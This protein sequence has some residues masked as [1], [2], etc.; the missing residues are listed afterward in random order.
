MPAVTVHL[1]SRA[2]DVERFFRGDAPAVIVKKNRGR[3]VWRVTAG[4]PALFVKRFPRELLRDRARHEADVLRAMAEAGL[5]C[6]RLVATAKDG[7]GSYVVTE[8][9]AGAQVLKALIAGGGHD[10]RRLLGAFADL[11]RRLLDAGFEHGDYHIGNVLVRDGEM[12]V[13]DVHRARKRR[14]TAARRADVVAFAAMSFL[15]LVPRTEVVRYIRKCGADAQDAIRRLRRHRRTYFE[16]RQERCFVE[17]SGFGADGRVFYRKGVDLEAVRAAVKAEGQT[18]KRTGS[19]SLVRLPRG[20]FV[21]RTTAARAKRIWGGAH[22]L[23]VRGIPTPRLHA[24]GPG[25]VVGDWIDAPNLGDVVRERFPVLPRGERD[26]LIFR[27]ARLVRRMHE[28]GALHK[29]LKSSNVLVGPAGFHFVDLDRVVTRSEVHQRQWT[30]ALAQLSASVHAAATRA[31]R[32]RFLYAYIGST[33][34]LWLRRREIAA[35]IM[36]QTRARKHLWP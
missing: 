8:E 19:E 31:D 23:A 10:A 1:P 33:R 30:F 7:E 36:K 32:L 2:P 24:C 4:E 22:A 17:G 21:K 34:A 35:A 13:L 29:D 11:T 9:I 3:T 5:P 25:W 12:F 16:S 15:D 20:W 6:P 28:R 27:L 18:V 26:A 14:P